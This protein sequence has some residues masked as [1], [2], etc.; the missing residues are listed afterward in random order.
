ML[1]TIYFSFGIECILTNKWHKGF[2]AKR[3]V[4]FFMFIKST[5]IKVNIIVDTQILLNSLKKAYIYTMKF[6]QQKLLNY[7]MATLGKCMC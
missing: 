7:R 4:E 3:N 2:S 6:S 5:H 1:L